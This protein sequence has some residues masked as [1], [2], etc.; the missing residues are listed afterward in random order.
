MLPIHY[1]SCTHLTRFLSQDLYTQ[2]R[3]SQ[4]K[5]KSNA[6]LKWFETTQAVNNVDAVI[7]S[8]IENF[9]IYSEFKIT[10]LIGCS[11]MFGVFLNLIRV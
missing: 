7:H 5:Q 9:L 4:S 8:L 10:I 1:S 6:V 11:R 3:K 2:H